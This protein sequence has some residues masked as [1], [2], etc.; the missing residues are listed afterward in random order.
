MPTRTGLVVS[1]IRNCHY[2]FW[3][4][5]ILWSASTSVPGASNKLTESGWVRSCASEWLNTWF[6]SMGYLSNGG[7]KTNEIWH[8]GSLG[9]EDDGRTSNTC[10]VQRKRAIP[11]STTKLSSI[12]T[13]LTRGRHVPANMW[14]ALRISVTVVTLLVYKLTIQIIAIQKQLMTVGNTW[15][16]R[17]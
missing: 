14:L 12:V 5:I 1:G 13:T 11:H 7:R 17:N 15:K 2:C 8:K 9:D 6:F 4:P 3:I 10:I 16:V